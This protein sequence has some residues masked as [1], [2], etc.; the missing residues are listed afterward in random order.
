MNPYIW[1]ALV[2]LL[3][4]VA[5]LVR[6]L[7]GPEP[8]DRMLAVQLFGTGG[9]AVLLTLAQAVQMPSLVDVA[10]IY[11][12]LAAVTIMVFVKWQAREKTDAGKVSDEFH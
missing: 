3:S 4:V 5:G 10:L 1:I 7:R 2:I 9:V 11:A 8:S 12:L 6:T